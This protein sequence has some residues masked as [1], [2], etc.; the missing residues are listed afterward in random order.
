MERVAP[1]TQPSAAPAGPV[2][3]IP[4]SGPCGDSDKSAGPT[5]PEIKPIA[6][7]PAPQRRV[8]NKP[9]RLPAP[10]V[11]KTIAAT[12]R[13]TNK[14]RIRPHGVERPISPRN[15]DTGMSPIPLIRSPC[16]ATA[17]SNLAGEPVKNNR[18][19][20]HTSELQPH[21]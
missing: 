9:S 19:E 16:T 21:S 11:Y 18:S 7:R 20:E 3:K 10:E 12:P 6:A 1:M 13:T 4:S 8:R 5:Y 15:I 17:P 14:T 2:R